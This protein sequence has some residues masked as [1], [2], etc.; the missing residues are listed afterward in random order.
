MSLDSSFFN[1]AEFHFMK[2]ALL[3]AC[4]LAVPVMVPAQ[5]SN[6][7]A[8]TGI[9]FA[10]FYTTN[11]AGAERF[12]GS[13]LGFNGQQVGGDRIYP[14][15]RSQWIEVT[16][17]TPQDPNVR[18]A[19]VAFTT[20][21][22]AALQRYLKAHSVAIETP[23]KKGEFAVRDPEGNLVIFVQRDSNRVVTQAQPAPN[24]TS[25]RIIHVGFVV[26]DREKED[27]FWRTLLGFRPY[28]YGGQTDA[29]TDYVALQVPDGTDWLEYMLNSRSTSNLQQNGVMDH[30]S[31]GVAHMSD[32]L[33]ALQR[34]QCEGANCSKTQIGRDGKVQLNLFDPDL[35]RVE[36]ME[37][38]PM[39]EPC[40]SPFTGKHPSAE[41]DR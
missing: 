9:A 28:W 18:M 35:T 25:G 36:F 15:N 10:R 34:N 11:V 13:T 4:V 32:V 31:L 22:A 27:A 19:A 26:K 23:L 30:F 37:F 3:L 2:R 40:C 39:R 17:A 29:R 24:A 14:V 21:D 1:Q 38:T 6:R 5:Q 41:E 7:P 8:I 33:A 12:Y 16:S 20:R